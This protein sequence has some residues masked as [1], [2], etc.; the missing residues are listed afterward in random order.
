MSRD[1]YWKKQEC[2]SCGKSADI[3]VEE[4][5][6]WSFRRRMIPARAIQVSDGFEVVDDGKAVRCECGE[7]ISI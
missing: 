6:E 3:R 4:N 1:R 2:A 5:D 7:R